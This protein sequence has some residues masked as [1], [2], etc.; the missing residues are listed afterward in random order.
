MW[1][2]KDHIKWSFPFLLF[3]VFLREENIIYT[4]KKHA[5]NMVTKAKQNGCHVCFTLLFACTLH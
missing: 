1:S 4:K 5:V 2:N 3:L